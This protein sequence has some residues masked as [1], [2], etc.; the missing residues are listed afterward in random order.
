MKYNLIALACAIL[1]A[2]GLSLTV[3]AGPTEPDT[4]SDGI[5][6]IHDNCDVV[7][8]ADQY[9]TDQDGYGQ[10][11]DSD[12]NQDGKSNVTDFITFKAAYGGLPPTYDEQNDYQ[13]D[14][15]VNVTDFI[16]FKAHY[17]AVPSTG[18]TCATPNTKGGCP[19][20]PA[21]P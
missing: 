8:N 6:D 7:P 14:G 10:A 11:C 2:V 15:K 3:V 13:C 12:F 5:V 4:D 16:T 19:G 21:C 18:Q 9:D 1:L 17:G 20:N